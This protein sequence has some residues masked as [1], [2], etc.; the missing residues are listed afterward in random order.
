LATRKATTTSMKSGIWMR[1]AMFCT[2]SSKD[3]PMRCSLSTIA[4]SSPS[5]P[6]WSRTRICS[7]TD[8]ALPARNALAMKSKASG[9]SA[10]MRS[11]RFLRCQAK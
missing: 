1:R 2:A 4:N 11:R 10:S 3:R 6:F 8:S 7:A 5:G 9:S